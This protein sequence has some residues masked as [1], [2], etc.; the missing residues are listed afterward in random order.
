[1]TDAPPTL[2]LGRYRRI[3]RFA[4]PVMIQSWWF[5]LVLPMIGLRA[6]SDRNR[7]RRMTAIARRYH[8]LAVDLGGLMIKVGQFLSSRLDVLPP[9]VTSE[10]AGLQDEVAPVAFDQIRTAAEASLGQSLSS[11]FASIDPMPL[12]AASLGQVHRARLHPS[13]AAIAGFSDVVV[14]IQ[15]PGI[16]L[17]VDTDLA[18]LRRIADLLSRVK[19]VSRRVD[20]P[21][22]V[23]EFAAVSHHEIDYV[24]EAANADRFAENIA[25]RAGVRAPGIAWELSTTRVL[26]L[27][28]V[29]AIKI[30]DTVALREAGIDPAE[31]AS[32]F[33]A[34]M[35]DQ[36]FRDGFFHADPHPGNLFVTP[37]PGEGA[38]FVVTFIDFG[39]MAEIPSDLRAGLRR[40]II[41]VATRDGRGLVAAFR[42]VGVLL[43]SADDVLLE[44]ALAALFDRFGGMGFAELQDVDPREFHTF[45]TDFG[46]L[47]RTLPFQL[48]E[49]FLLIIRAVSLTSGVCSALNPAFNVWD[50]VE[51]YAD[52][53]I[54]QETGGTAR[55]FLSDAMASAAMFA[56]LPRRID[57]L[58]TK[59]DEG[60]LVVDT[61]RL[62]RQVE[63]I[64]RRGI[65][66]VLAAGILIGGAVLHAS[67]DVA[68]TV[69]MIVSAV[70]ALYAIWGAR[71]RRP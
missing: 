64:A 46:D 35:F 12:A 59:L 3:M 14:K 33:A 62:E 53:L 47:V 16:G 56:R 22:L 31:V 61:R 71:R 52:E 2:L 10:L 60:R 70:P 6:V 57:D 36:V 17:I 50:A 67:A 55:A 51:P 32:A 20:V 25:G 23:E 68:G 29:S 27:E 1:M 26:A 9:E 49:N 44:E 38:G 69:L 8:P 15:R 48:P 30:S 28:D 41:A 39:M 45:A 24:H 58:V 65:A 34:A 5:E 13:D 40:I 11:A 4:T 43:P 19:M 66:G 21:A 63:G 42:D 54:K 18:A 7:T 37:T